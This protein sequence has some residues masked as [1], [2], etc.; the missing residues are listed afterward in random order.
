M[1]KWRIYSLPVMIV[2]AFVY[3][4]YVW[5]RLAVAIQLVQIRKAFDLSLS[6]A[7]L[8][9]TVFTIGITLGS[10]PAGIFNARF[11]TRAGLVVG[12]LLFS[13][14]TAWSALSDSLISILLSRV[15]G[16][17]GEAFFSVALYSFLSS[18]TKTHKGTAVGF[19]ATLFGIGVFSA[20][21]VISSFFHVTKVWQ[22]P[23]E[24]LAALGAIGALAIWIL[25][26]AGTTNSKAEPKQGFVFA[27]MLKLLN[28]T[29]ILLL[30]V[31][32][33]DGI[34]IYSFIGLFMTFLRGQQHFGLAVA[35]G[36]ISLFGIGQLCGGVPM[37]YLADR[38]GRR[39]LLTVG[40]VLVAGAGAVVFIDASPLALSVL[41]FLFGIGTNSIYTNCL[42]MA[43]ER[44]E[45]TDIPLVT[46]MLSTVY[47]LTAAFSGWMLVMLKQ[48]LGWQMAGA[49]LYT[50][51]FILLIAAIWLVPQ[52]DLKKANA[53]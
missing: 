27:R 53:S 14:C 51:P 25:A 46:G 26:P 36:V 44:V 40:F 22:G 29:N 13:F 15:V 17:V 43:Q 5:D 1:A 47:F 18:R 45:V 7:G 35:S 16:G 8:L 10:I 3:L 32:A 42:A 41:A 30:I 28:R 19:P 2:L 9:A 39:N 12:A 24:I 48:A 37:G 52:R 38:A 49:M 34:G 21:L 6:S 50:L 33:A 4:V 23:F 11:G 20:P 31:M